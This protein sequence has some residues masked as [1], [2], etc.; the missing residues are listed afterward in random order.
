[1]G[2]LQYRYQLENAV[3]AIEDL[4]EYGSVDQADQVL[5][6]IEAEVGPLA[7]KHILWQR[8]NG[9]WDI[10][11]LRPGYGCRNQLLASGLVPGKIP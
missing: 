6:Q 8:A 4:E 3:L 1:M 10:P 9:H 7:G 11:W 2:R 5:A